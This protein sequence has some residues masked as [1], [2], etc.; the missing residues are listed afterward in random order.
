MKNRVKTL[1]TIGL[2]LVT[3]GSVLSMSP[4][5]ATAQES[6]KIANAMSAGPIA[7]TAEATILDWPSDPAGDMIVLREGTNGWTCFTDW[8]A[9]PGND[10]MCLD[11]V[12]VDWSNALALGEKPNVT[13]L[14][15][16]YMLAG[17]SSASNTDPFAMEPARIRSLAPGDGFFVVEGVMGLFDGSFEGRGSTAELAKVLDF[18]GLDWYLSWVLASRIASPLVGDPELVLSL[19]RRA[20][21][22]LE[23]A[24]AKD[25][26]SRQEPAPQDASWI[27]DYLL[28]EAGQ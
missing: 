6:D 5:P 10:P 9:T 18:I 4:D 21:F 26:G 19:E 14:G 23:R 22:E 27:A 8:P 3:L 20:A 12:W 28:T 15:F 24:F 1:A 11:Q 16:G 25:A 13:S 7:I 17:G 2:Q